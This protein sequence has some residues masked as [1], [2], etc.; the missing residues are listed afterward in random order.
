MTLKEFVKHFDKKNAIVLLEGKRKVLKQDQKKLF[1]L[2]KLLSSSTQHILFRSGNATGADEH[3]AAALCEQNPERMQV[4]T[5][6]SGHRKKTNQALQTFALNELNLAHN[7]KLIARLNKIK[8][9]KKFVNLYLIGEQN[10]ITTKS[11]YLIRDAIKVIGAPK[12]KPA[13]FAIFYDD[14][15]N[16]QQGGTGFTINVCQQLKVPFIT[17]QVWFNWLNEK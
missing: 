7:P 6:Y 14:L 1:L 16:P 13:T 2:G 5:P 17:Q 11:A 4:I 9:L 3:F 8:D 15:K 10:L 12:I